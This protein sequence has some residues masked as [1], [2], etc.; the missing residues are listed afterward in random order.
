MHV[1]R[2]LVIPGK[3]HC[4]T[5]ENFTSKKYIIIEKEFKQI[6]IA[7]INICIYVFICFLDNF[8]QMVKI[9]KLW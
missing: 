3:N 2:G 4:F 7:R 8:E 6:N 5:M 9:G 1:I